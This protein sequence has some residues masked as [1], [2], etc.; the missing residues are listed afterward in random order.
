MAVCDT[1]KT[2]VHDLRATVVYS[3]VEI[4]RRQDGLGSTF[5]RTVAGVT[6]GAAACVESVVQALQSEMMTPPAATSE[7]APKE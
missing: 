3:T 2:E 4:G 1:C 5:V 7:E 6:C